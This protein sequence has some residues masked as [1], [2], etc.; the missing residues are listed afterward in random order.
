MNVEEAK[1]ELEFCLNEGHCITC[2]YG[3]GG[4]AILSCR[5]MLTKC[6]TVLENCVE[7]VRCKD[8]KYFSHDVPTRPFCRYYGENVSLMHFCSHGERK[9]E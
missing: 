2:D 4:K 7:V 9:E 3:S 5:E 8:C 1:K 6:L